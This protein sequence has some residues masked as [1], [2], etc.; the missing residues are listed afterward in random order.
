MTVVD[1]THQPTPPSEPEASATQPRRLQLP[2]KRG[3]VD[4]LFR[5]Q[6]QF[7]DE[8]KELD[9][10]FDRQTSAVVQVGRAILQPAQSE[11]LDR[12]VA[13]LSREP[14]HLQIMHQVVK[15][16]RRRMTQRALC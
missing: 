7:E 9:G 13:R 2:Q 3:E 14:F 11:G 15:I 16:E 1:P 8:V 4:L 10:V 12:S 5:R 6:L